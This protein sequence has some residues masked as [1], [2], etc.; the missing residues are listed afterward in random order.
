MKIYDFDIKVLILI[1]G[2]KDN[3]YTFDKKI[4]VSASDLYTAQFR[5]FQAIK[6]ECLNCNDLLAQQVY[7]DNIY[8]NVRYAL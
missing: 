1:D 4:S 5:A 2:S 7:A 6:K 3:V 8:F